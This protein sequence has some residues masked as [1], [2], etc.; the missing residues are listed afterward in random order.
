MLPFGDLNRDKPV[1]RAVEICDTAEFRR[2]DERAL[3]IIRPAVIGAAQVFGFAF[4]LGHDSGSVMTADVEE[5]TQDAV[6]SAN[7]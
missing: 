4:G 7:D 3:K 6:V 5:T 2:M 1:C